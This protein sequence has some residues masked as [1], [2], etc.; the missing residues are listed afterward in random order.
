[1][2]RIVSAVRSELPGDRLPVLQ[3]PAHRRAHRPRLPG[4]RR[5]AS[6]P[7]PCSPSRPRS[8]SPSTA[9]STAGDDATVN[10]LLDGFY[11]PLVEPPQPGPRLRRLAGQGR[12]AAAR[13]GR[14]RGAAAAVGAGPRARQGAGRADRARPGPARRRLTG[15]RTDD[16]DIAPSSTPGTSS[17]TRPPPRASPRLGVEQVTLAS[18]YHSTRALTPRHP[19]HRVVTAEHAAVLYPPDERAGGAASCGRTRPAPGRPA[20]PW[21]EAAEALAAAGLEVHTWVVLAHNSRLGAE[22][23]RTSVVNAYG[24]R[25][26]WA[27]CIARPGRPRATCW[28]SPP[29]PPC[30]PAR[31]APNWSPSAGTA[32]PTC[33]PTTRSRGVALGDAAQYLMSLCFCPAC[34]DGYAGPAPTPTSWPRPS[35]TRWPRCWARARTAA[36][37]CGAAGAARS[38]RRGCSATSRPPSTLDWRREQARSLQEQAVAAVR[39]AAPARLPGADARRPG[40]LPLRRERRA[41]TR[42]TSSPT[43]TAWCCPAPAAPR[44]ATACSARRRARARAHVLAANFTVVARHGRQPR[45][46]GRGRRARGRARRD[47]N[48]GSTTRDWPPTRT[49]RGGARKALAALWQRFPERGDHGGTAALRSFARR[50]TGGSCTPK[51]PPGRRRLP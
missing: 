11:R 22:H 21:G 1:M 7:R 41:W 33:T 28:T 10:R 13:P 46:A 36:D 37:R 38:D 42:R 17:A 40:R 50:E 24:D 35:A 30:G 25:Y 23:P 15:R 39:A 31:A 48:C 29:R 44:P 34:R 5:H 12:G 32:S 49:S 27:P 45:H 6:T 4:H 20:T 3:R 51:S 18:A 47:A 2:Q 19:R 26:P 16:E 14:R 9:R 8:P 43:P